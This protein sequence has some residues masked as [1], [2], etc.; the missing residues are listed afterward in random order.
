MPQF[1]MPGVN[2]SRVGARLTGILA[3]A[4]A[5]CVG[6]AITAFDNAG[7]AR[8]LRLQLRTDQVGDG[9]T[10]GTRIRFDGV[11]VGRVTAVDALGDA[12]QMLSV[13]LDR[14]QVSALTDT[15]RVDYAPEN[16]FGI[17]SLALHSG[18]GG[19][20]LRAGTV[21]DLTGRT[22]D[23][24][25]GTLLRSLT[26]TSTEV[27]TPQLTALL[28]RVGSDLRAFTPILR[29][30][31]SLGRT[32]ADT[33]QYLP[34]YLID[35]YAQFLDGTGAFGSSTFVLLHSVLNIEAFVTDRP[36]YDAGV[37][38]IANELFPTIATT[39]DTARKHL[40]GYADVAAPL[41][42]AIAATVPTPG[43]SQA[44]LSEL[45]TRLDRIFA[46]APEGPRVR[47]AM[48]L[49]TVPGLAVP[50]LGQ[51]AALPV[52]SPEGVRWPR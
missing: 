2:I 4:L 1:T 35:Q 24:T 47:V 3:V 14:T 22:T 23:L 44:E 48:V 45:L 10:T 50:L 6:V 52:L 13:E 16:L 25:M 12:A 40:G 36:G 21:L 37:D 11:E 19:Q 38:M 27:F 51:S 41:L 29:A 28:T 33:Q 34:S 30:M 43:R 42:S 32:V 31:V 46:E 26:E 39:L 15:L 20:P 8:N 18:V 17:T 49:R 7:D 9:V 5:V